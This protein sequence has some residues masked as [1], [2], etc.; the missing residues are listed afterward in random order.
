MD[1][2]RLEL[3]E[4]D[5]ESTRT[6]LDEAFERFET[7]QPVLAA[8]V[9]E[10]LAMPIDEAAMGLGY[11]LAIAVWLGFEQVYGEKLKSIG[12]D[13]L[14]ATRELLIL[15]EQ[16]R[17]SDPTDVL[18]TDDIIAMEQPELLEFVHDHID[19]TLE[20][21]TRDIDVDDIHEIYR[22]IL[23]EILA[24]SYSV[25]RPLGFPVARTELLA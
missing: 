5:E 6:Q 24:L 25:E 13:E 15:D 11:F 12:N 16:L 3:S 10:S 1:V 4:G 8:H 18:E 23:T 2:L 17:Q 20:T 9:T 21:N 19:A 7:R 14:Q 22:V